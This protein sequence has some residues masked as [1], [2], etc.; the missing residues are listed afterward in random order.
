MSVHVT[1]QLKTRP[2]HI[3]EVIDK[4]RQVLTESLAREGCEAIHI[5]PFLRRDL[6]P[7][8][9]AIAPRPRR[10]FMTPRGGRATSLPPGGDD[11]AAA[12]TTRR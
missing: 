7:H 9:R 1:T 4:L 3:D 8:P 10:D 6:Q 11:A 2:E 12:R 5:D